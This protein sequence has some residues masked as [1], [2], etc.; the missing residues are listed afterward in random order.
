MLEIASGFTVAT[1]RQANI[2]FVMLANA[3]AFTTPTAEFYNY[4]YTGTI[5]SSLPDSDI[6]FFTSTVGW[7]MIGLSL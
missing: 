5:D 7:P 3:A 4:Q 2:P 6:N 1:G